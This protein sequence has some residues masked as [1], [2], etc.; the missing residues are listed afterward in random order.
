MR[1]RTE[2]GIRRP[3]RWLLAAVAM[4]AL[5]IGDLRSQPAVDLL[6]VGGLVY[7]G[8]G[9]PPVRQDVGV[10]GE[11]ISFVGDA[12][13]AGLDAAEVADVAGLMIAP[14]FI[15]MHSHA[16]LTEDHGHDALPFLH[17]GITTVAIGWTV[18]ARPTS[19]SCSPGS[20]AVSG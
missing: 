8:S 4:T 6:L 12:A 20:R 7:D 9:E 14:G 2:C 1:V 17:Q 18:R 16:E 15:D 3:R 11:R 19:P 10:V 13:A 5:W